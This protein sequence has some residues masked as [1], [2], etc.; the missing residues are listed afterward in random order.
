MAVLRSLAGAR[1]PPR[2]RPAAREA[3]VDRS[4]RMSEVPSAELL[5]VRS[6]LLRKAVYYGNEVEICGSI[7]GIRTEKDQVWLDFRATGTQSEEL[8]RVLSGRKKRDLVVHLCRDGCRKDV[9]DSNLVHADR[10]ETVDPASEEWF[11]NVE[12]VRDDEAMEDDEDELKDLRR[13]A[14]EEAARGGEGPPKDKKKKKKDKK[15][16]KDS[17]EEAEKKEPAVEEELELG[18]KSLKSLFEDT[19]LDPRAKVRQKMFRRAK[20]MKKKKSKKKKKSSSGGSGSES[21]SGSTSSTSTGRGEED[22]LFDEDKSL[23]KI[24]KRYPGVLS[25]SV[26]GEARKQLVTASGTAWNLDRSGVP[27]VMTHYFRQTLAPA[28]SPP[29]QQESLTIA[30]CMDYC[31]QGK[32]A[33][34][35]DI[36]AQRLKSLESNCR[37]AHWSVARQ[38]ELL[39]AESSGIVQD[40]E[41]RLAAAKR[42]REETRLQ[43]LVKQPSSAKGKEWNTGGKGKRGKEGKNQGKNQNDSRGKGNDSWKDD[44]RDGQAS[45]AEAPRA[46]FLQ[47]L[48]AG[49]NS[50]YGVRAQP[51]QTETSVAL[52]VQKRLSEC[53]KSTGLMEESLPRTSFDE[54]FRTRG[55]DY[56]GEEVKVARQMTWEGVRSALPDQV[57]SLDI[58][59][60]CSEGVLHFVNNFE[61]F[62]VPPEMRKVGKPPRVLCSDEEWPLIAQ[63][64]VDFGICT[65]V[66]ESELVRINGLPLLNGLFSVT[67]D[68]FVND[69]ELLRLIMNLKPCNVLCRTLSGDIATLPTITNMGAIYLSEDESLVVSSEDL[70]CF[71]YLFRIPE[72]WIP[73]M[74]FGREVPVGLG[75]G[76]HVGK[77]YLASRVLPMGWLNS[78]GI[79]QHI[80]RNV[81]RKAMGSLSPRWGGECEMRRDRVHTSSAN[82]FRVYLDNFDCLSKVSRQTAELL[83]GHVAPEVA[84]LREVYSFFGLPTHP[85]K[86]VAQQT[87]AEVQ[88]A[89]VNGSTGVVSPKPSKVAKYIGLAVQLLL[90]G[91]ASQRELQVVGG[92]FVYAAMFRRPL[93]ASLNSIWRMIVNLEGRGMLRARLPRSVVA[94][95]TRFIC[96]VPLASMSLRSPFDGMV[97]ASDASNEGGGVCMSSGLSSYGLAAA[98]SSVRGDLYEPHDLTQVLTIGLFDGISALRVAMDTLAVPLAGHIS[99]EQNKE[100]Q[101]VVEAFYPETMF[102]NNIEEVDATMVQSWS[103]QFT[104][105][106]L[107]FVGA[108]PPCQGVSKL[109]ADRRGALRDSRSS[110][111]RH[112]PRIVQLVQRAFPWAQV[113]FLAENVASM[114][115][116]DCH[117]MNEGYETLPWMIDAVGCSLARRPR[118]YWLSWELSP[119]PGVHIVRGEPAERTVQGTVYLK[120]QVSESDFLE[121]GWHLMEGQVLPTFTTSR[122]SERPMRKPAGMR[123]CTELELLRW[124]SDRHRFPPYQYRDV[125]CVHHSR[126]EARPPSVVEREAILG[127]PLHYT[128]QCMPKAQHGTLPHE[129]CRLTLLGNS[130]SVPVIAWLVS[131]LFSILGISHINSLA[132]IVQRTTPGKQLGLQGLLLRPPLRH[133]TRTFP[134]ETQLVQKLCGLTS[135]KGE[136][137]LV[138]AE[139]EQPARYHRLRGSIPARLWRWRVVSGWKWQMTGEHIN[140]LELRAVLTTVRWRVEQLRQMDVRC[141]H[142][143][144]SLVALHTLSR[145]RSSSHKLQRIQVR[146]NL[147]S[148][149]SLTVQPRTKARYEVSLQRFFRF[150]KGEALSLPKKRE[151]MDALV[152]DY[153]EHLWSSG[154]GRAEGS[155][156]LAALQDN[157][158][159]LKHRLPGSWRLMKAWVTHEVPNRAPPFS[160]QVLQAM[161]GWSRFHGHHS[162]ALSLL[163]GFFG[164][165]RTGELLDL[166]ASQVYMASSI[167]PAVRP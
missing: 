125:H 102:V 15:S 92:G 41:G 167:S 85:K 120:A 24:W 107:V 56:A 27:P 165:L 116:Q 83:A 84:H 133:D 57:G 25:A 42:A 53:L 51:K 114:D 49:L 19:G 103:Q 3:V 110:L 47:A 32:V 118:L 28:M 91:C 94:E 2:M 18:Q 35:M 82:L 7:T 137:L 5:A 43:G 79:A 6:M 156:I 128:R 161:V 50:M 117:T 154:E 89:L 136:D 33:S 77:R 147:G 12:A 105:V 164:M 21:S 155:T 80:H 72:A 13:K 95:L 70:R 146:K 46:K 37:G 20:K 148:L 93:L 139:S 166:R 88:G 153:L 149:K 152:S 106:G 16:K 109:N 60:F 30:Q 87:C 129:D 143:V 55:L 111:F 59:D 34:A 26:V 48:S 163:V 66:G 17:K 73:Y 130:W 121:P 4:R 38:H 134:Q 90:Q 142:L 61:S 124:K 97:T 54:F 65:T 52:R 101:R 127:F 39:R 78:V 98:H 96:L 8:L 67:K 150:L 31:L 71:F 131:Q 144:D 63:G 45:H 99:V 11:T 113:H 108:G 10:F 157:D 1:P 75:D 76:T 104:C 135:L 112:V 115:D 81:I 58:R 23:V 122:P 36:M 64:L 140:S 126:R 162:F 29:M 62:L 119:G 22:D 145:G 123:Q 141:V 159:K 86:S 14:E 74:A 100:A 69:T 44:G 151:Q 40:S 138:Q 68:E 158:P 9:T 132:E 160:E